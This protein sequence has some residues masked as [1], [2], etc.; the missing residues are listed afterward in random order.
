M[1]TLLSASR[2]TMLAVEEIT[3]EGDP[4]NVSTGT[5][6]SFV[7]ILPKR[8]IRRRSSSENKR[9]FVR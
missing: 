2:L 7:P 4:R 1:C 6:S 9:D 8:H 5:L 3:V